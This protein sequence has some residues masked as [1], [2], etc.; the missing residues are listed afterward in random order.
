MILKNYNKTIRTN[1]IQIILTTYKHNLLCNVI[2]N[3]MDLANYAVV[4]YFLGKLQLIKIQTTVMA[5]FKLLDI[6]L[7][8]IYFCWSFIIF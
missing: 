1:D 2:Y 5:N 3:D 4:I 6:I 7:T 8:K